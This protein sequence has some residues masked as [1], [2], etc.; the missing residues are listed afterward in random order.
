[1]EDLSYL[2]LC[3]SRIF[4]PPQVLRNT[5]VDN[6]ECEHLA[7]TCKTTLFSTT[8]ST[9]SFTNKFCGLRVHKVFFCKVPAKQ[10]RLLDKDL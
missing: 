8:F 9:C 7:V 4:I 5:C 2:M 1:M 10:N 6:M 3:L